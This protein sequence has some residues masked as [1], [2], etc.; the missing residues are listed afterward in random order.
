MNASNSPRHHFRTSLRFEALERREL[1][2]IDTG[3]LTGPAVPPPAFLLSQE[4]VLQ[5]MP[6]P[7]YE[8]T[9]DVSEPAEVASAANDASPM[10]VIST[11]IES[12]SDTM[13]AAVDRCFG[14]MG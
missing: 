11:A 7:G 5:S 10:K 3:L 4:T 2:T 9:T 13:T 1:L 6:M 14:E 8:D 12:P